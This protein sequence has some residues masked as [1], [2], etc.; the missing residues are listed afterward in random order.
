MKILFLGD[1]V[2]RV[3][4]RLVA[5]RAAA[6]A[7]DHGAELIVAN[8]E[9]AAAG[10]GITPSTLAALTKAGVDVATSG[11]HVFAQREAA[12]QM[13]AMPTLVRPANYPPGTPGRGYVVVTTPGGARVAVV[14]LAGRV[15]MDCLDCPF[16]TADRVLEE[17]AGATVVVDF[18]AEATSEKEAMGHY[19]DGRVA[20]VVGTHTHVQTADERVLPGGTAYITDVGMT[21]AAGGVIGTEV[22]PVLRRLVGK[23]PA[24]FTP[25][26]GEGILGAVVLDLDEAQGRARRIVRILERRA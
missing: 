8:V 25:A 17:V 19:L 20:A 21:G 24:R 4:R 15:F 16:R 23:M 10:A 9:N 14:N 22:G 11:N 7:A 5:E 3:G 13:D 18:H 2:G 1:V 6:L 12:E 26:E